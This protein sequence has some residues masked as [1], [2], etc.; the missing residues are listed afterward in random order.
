VELHAGDEPAPIV[1]AALCG[2]VSHSQPNDSRGFPKSDNE[3]IV[4]YDASQSVSET[5]PLK[6]GSLTLA[7]VFPT[8]RGKTR[9]FLPF[10]GPP[11]R[12]DT[13]A[14]TFEIGDVEE[15]G[16]TM[17]T[18]SWQEVGQQTSWT[19]KLPGGG[20]F[21]WQGE[22]IVGTRRRGRVEA[23]L[24]KRI[25][26]DNVE[27]LQLVPALDVLE[28]VYS[29][30]GADFADVQTR[31]QMC[32]VTRL[33]V[34]RDFDGVDSFPLWVSG[35]RTVNRDARSIVSS[36]K[37]GELNGALTLG[38]GPRFGWRA[39]MYDKHRESRGVAPE[40][41]V[42]FEG[43]CRRELMRS[44]WAK[45][46]GGVVVQ[47]VDIDE[48][49][50]RQWTRALFVRV[51]YER[52]VSSVTAISDLVC[53]SQLSPTEKRGLL[54]YLWERASGVDFGGSPH[55][56]RKYERLARS[57]GVTLPREALDGRDVRVRMDFE[58]GTEVAR[59]A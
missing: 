30:V 32:E 52:E 58:R 50:L 1:R 4:G 43:R 13:V 35:Q 41:R 25:G 17:T 8:N 12:L 14:I 16:A 28:S 10:E 18:G 29:E 45:D 19:R 57:L 9:H 20:V 51:G 54:G 33:D 56:V 39:T 38:V 21:Q 40:G 2:S 27:G 55:T 42:R 31:F 49:K 34:V 5:D 26:D 46:N 37:S 7:S 22:N 47:V 59:A 3:S 53:R 48:L 36:F 24:P 23:S 44:E 6:P 15:T 11:A